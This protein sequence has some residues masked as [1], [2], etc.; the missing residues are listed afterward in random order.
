MITKFKLL[1]VVPFIFVLI[2]NIVYVSLGAFI[3]IF[4]KDKQVFYSSTF[5]L[6]YIFILLALNIIFFISILIMSNKFI[7][8]NIL[9]PLNEFYIDMQ[10]F[11]EKNK[12]GFTSWSQRIIKSSREIMNI[13]QYFHNNIANQMYLLYNNITYD[14][15][16]G[17]RTSIILRQDLEQ[18]PNHVIAVLNLSNFKEINSFYGVKLADD[19]LHSVANVLKSY[20]KDENYLLYRIHGD[21]FAILWI[22]CTDKSIFLHKLEG[23]LEYL[24]KKEILIDNYTYLNI[25]ATIGI[26]FSYDSAKY[27]MVNA[28]MALHH[29]K[30]YKN[31]IVVYDRNLPILNILKNNIQYT[32]IIYQA[33]KDKNI[34]PFYQKID[35]IQDYLENDKVKYEALMRIKDRDGHMIVPGLFLEVAKR[36]SSYSKLSRMMIEASFLDLSK[37]ENCIFS[38]N[39]ALEDMNSVDFLVWFMDR[40]IYYKLEGRVVVEITEQESV[41][42]FDSVNS[43]ITNIKELGIKIALDDFG[44]GYSNFSVLMKLQIDY[45]KIDGS[46]IKNIDK[47]SNARIIVQTIVQFAKLLNIK[48]IAEFVSSKEVYDVVKYMGVD[49][50]QGYYIGKPTQEI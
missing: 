42:D 33:L 47:D 6:I 45:L 44:S 36:S 9:N 12:N 34:I 15:L 49:Y 4:F 31:P 20:F 21:D 32:E 3:F 7:K 28:I 10:N 37:R 43:F 24:G 27:S 35:I 8:D 39:L 40:I 2:I 14:K 46:L 26:A 18:Y 23:F 41:E 11:Y 16:T 50:A 25:A 19:I 17:L 13:S 38:V 22:N 30:E 29:A 5:I 1:L 48:T